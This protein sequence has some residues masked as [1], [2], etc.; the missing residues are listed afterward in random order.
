MTSL[1]LI[2][3]PMQS[4]LIRVSLICRYPLI[5]HLENHCS[6]P[7]QRL[8]A[9]IMRDVFGESLY[10]P[11]EHPGKLVSL[12]SPEELAEKILIAV[13]IYSFKLLARSNQINQLYLPISD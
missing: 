8:V 1:T 3:A 2:Q 10:L 6:V 13:I 4:S 5:I 9:R 12:C 11:E 7:Q